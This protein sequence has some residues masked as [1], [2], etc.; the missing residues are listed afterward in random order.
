MTRMAGS[1]FGVY[2]MEWVG[3][4]VIADLRQE[5]FDQYVSL[6]ATFY[7]SFSSGQLISKLAYN[8]EQVANAAT[9][10]IVSAMR[11]VC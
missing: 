8:S 2:G 9:K 6:P 3:R 5:L 10:S 4:R 11:D 7:D 1:F